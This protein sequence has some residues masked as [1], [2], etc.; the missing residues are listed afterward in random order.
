MVAVDGLDQRVNRGAIYGF[1][2]RNGAGK[3]TTI[4][5]LLGMIMPTA[6]ST[7]VL[8][9]GVRADAPGLW[10]RVGHLVESATAYLELSV[11][12]LD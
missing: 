5:M 4:R 2:G 8:G 3:S 6:G 1:L 12:Q 10:R 7:N 11:R 9:E